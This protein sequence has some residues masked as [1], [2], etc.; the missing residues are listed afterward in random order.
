MPWDLD[1]AFVVPTLDGTLNNA[2][3]LKYPITGEL[4]QQVT[5]ETNYYND[6]II[7]RAI[8]QFP[9]FRQMFFR[10]SMN[11]Y[12]QIW[13]NDKYL[14]WFDE[15]FYPSRDELANDLTEWNPARKAIYESFFPDGLPWDVPPDFPFDGFDPENF[16]NYLDQQTPEMGR[17]I[18]IYG[19]NRFKN[20]VASYRADGQLLPPQ[21]TDEEK[22]IQ[23]TEINYNPE[24]NN[25]NLEFIELFNNSDK[26]VDVSGWQVEGVEFT[27]PAG[28]V[29]APGGYGVIV[30]DDQSFRA[31]YPSVLVYGQYSGELADSGET[32]RLLD[33]TGDQISLV[34]YRSSGDWPSVTDGQGYTLSLIR[35]NA[36]ETLAVCWAPSGQL[37]G[38]PGQ[39]N[40]IDQ[41]WAGANSSGCTDRVYSSSGAQALADTG[42]NRDLLI[43]IAGSLITVASATRFIQP[44]YAKLPIRIKK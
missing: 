13:A 25:T 31:E 42:T 40:V 35:T 23:I 26:A 33:E 41:Q 18:Y 27:F 36:N 6:A 19:A 3:Y 5:G 44:A 15:F 8:Y 22:R 34:G 11:V 24:G 32:L 14:E 37:G 12:D 7:E 29:I 38:T 43:I 39:A 4:K 17:E 9:E 2:E 30:K 28:S 21:K 20:M 10:R 1:N 16:F